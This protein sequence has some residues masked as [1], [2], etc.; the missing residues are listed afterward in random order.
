MYIYRNF[1]ACIPP[2]CTPLY[3]AILTNSTAVC[4][5][6]IHAGADVNLRRLGMS[7]D[8][9]SAESPLIKYTVS[10]NL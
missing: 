6:L 3:R 1:V 5:H 10:N 8:T 2:G 9:A 4:G 7:G